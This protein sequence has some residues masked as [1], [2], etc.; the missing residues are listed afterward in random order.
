MKA[1]KKEAWMAAAARLPLDFPNKFP[2]RTEVAIPKEYGAWKV[3]EAETMRTDWAAK[4]TG[5][6]KLA[7]TKREG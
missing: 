6:N 5:P 4:T 7:A 2:M 1:R 3:D